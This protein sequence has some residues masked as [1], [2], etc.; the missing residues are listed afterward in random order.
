VFLSAT[1]HRVTCD[2]AG[3]SIAPGAD[4]AA[5]STPRS[6]ASERGFHDSVQMYTRHEHGPR[7][8]VSTTGS[9]GYL[10]FPCNP[11][12]WNMFKVLACGLA[13]FF[14]VKHLYQHKAHSSAK[15]KIMLI[16]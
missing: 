1:R 10:V 8:Q 2:S 15:N 4:V 3:E 6:P 5:R 16:N 12:I 7:T 9:T 14:T 11:S 13:D